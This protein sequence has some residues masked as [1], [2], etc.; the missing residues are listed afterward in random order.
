MDKAFMENK[1][2]ENRMK[3]YSTIKQL[4]DKY[5]SLFHL[6]PSSFSTFNLVAKESHL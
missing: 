1:N 4:K 6:S 2:L 5:Q 3:I